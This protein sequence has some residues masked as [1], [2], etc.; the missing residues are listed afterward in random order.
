MALHQMCS[1]GIRTWLLG[2]RRCKGQLSPKAQL[3]AACRGKPRPE[4]TECPGQR[5]QDSGPGPKGCR[6]ANTRTMH[7]SWRRLG[8]KRLSTAAWGSYTQ[9]PSNFT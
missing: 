5:G 8:V 3:N 9:R 2:E 7:F 1:G 4:G 6:E